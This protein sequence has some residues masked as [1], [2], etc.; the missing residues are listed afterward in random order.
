MTATIRRSTWAKQATW[1]VFLLPKGSFGPFPTYRSKGSSTAIRPAQCRKEK[2]TPSSDRRIES[3]AK[4][5]S[6]P[7]GAPL[8]ESEPEL[9]KEALVSLI[10][11]IWH[12]WLL[13][14]IWAAKILTLI[15]KVNTKVSFE[16]SDSYKYGALRPCG[17]SPL[18]SPLHGIL[19]VRILE[20]VAMPSSRGPSW[21]RDETHVSFISCIG[22]QFPYH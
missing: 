2:S 8:P 4:C 19:Q 3:E 14:L 7:P 21:F 18:D 1:F 11:L 17:P 9:Q 16:F 5:P 22:R 13:T 20:R 15:F 10:R 12:L 6:S